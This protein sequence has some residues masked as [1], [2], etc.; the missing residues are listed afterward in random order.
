MVDSVDNPD[1]D[2]D[3]INTVGGPEA[4]ARAEVDDDSAADVEDNDE[5]ESVAIDNG[6]SD[7]DDFNNL[8]H[9]RPGQLD[10]PE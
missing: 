5:D 3:P 2:K 10:D 7:G 6:S 4:V 1:E 9:P 8:T